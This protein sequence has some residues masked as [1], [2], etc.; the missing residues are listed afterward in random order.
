MALTCI[1]LGGIYEQNAAA[2]GGFQDLTQLT[3][4]RSRLRGL[5]AWIGN[6][7][8]KALHPPLSQQHEHN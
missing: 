5:S 8:P 3:D 1:V 7:I 4:G 6:G 2:A